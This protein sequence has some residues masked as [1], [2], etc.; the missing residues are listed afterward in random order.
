MVL[1]ADKQYDLPWSEQ[2][3][4]R[5]R[6]ELKHRLKLEGVKKRYDPFLQIKEE[7]ISDP[8]VDRYMDL[9]KKGR[10][11]GAPFSPK[12]FFSLVGVTLVPIFV[13]AHLIEWERKDYLIACANGDLSVAKRR[14]REN[15]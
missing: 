14:K 12:I 11:P 10:M 6:L 15:M 8:A 5:R 2:D 1:G 3:K 4:V 9:R 7:I 13:I